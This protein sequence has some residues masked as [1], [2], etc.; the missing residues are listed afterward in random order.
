MASVQRHTWAQTVVSLATRQRHYGV[1]KER[2]KTLDF[3]ALQI[4]RGGFFEEAIN[5]A[6][7]PL[8]VDYVNPLCSA[9]PQLCKSPYIREIL[10]T[11]TSKLT[12]RDI[13]SLFSACEDFVANAKVADKAQ[14]SLHVRRIF[15]YCRTR[16]SSGE[17]VERCGFT[18][19]FRWVPVRG[20]VNLL[21]ETYDDFFDD[22]FLRQPLTAVPQTDQATTD[23]LANHH[24]VSRL[25]RVMDS[26]AHIMND[27]DNYI[28]LV[29]E[30]RK[31][32]PLS[33]LPP[34]I[35]KELKAQGHNDATFF[36]EGASPETRLKA[37]LYLSK[38]HQ[39]HKIV[40][41]RR[42]F[43]YDIPAL[44]TISGE[45]TARY[46]LGALLSEFYL[47][48]L[49]LTAC[50]IILLAETGWNPDTLLS[51][52]SEN[53]KFHNGNYTIVGLKSKSTNLRKQQFHQFQTNQVEPKS[54]K[55]L[56][57]PLQSAP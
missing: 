42:L 14:H 52:K 50:F 19:R 47:P 56:R 17:T 18:S 35:A 1:L 5:D 38:K 20:S 23:A 26:C 13:H 34:R 22:E 10:G 36:L 40:P 27:Y 57:A 24:L 32:D 11:P 43:L 46:L 15:L 54:A 53:I 9:L 12:V 2:K 28:E 16:L 51:L 37:T 4:A 6:D 48:R 25:Q 30:I 41:R 44:V 31:S 8:L 39:Y 45:N 33:G 29:R 49:A 3:A 21:S 55:Q 7:A